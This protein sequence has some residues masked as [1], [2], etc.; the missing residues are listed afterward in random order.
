LQVSPQ[1]QSQ[2]VAAIWAQVSLTGMSIHR[3]R[4]KGGSGGEIRQPEAEAE[5][6]AEAVGVGVGV[7]GGSTVR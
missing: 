6:E 2:A 4:R 3:A 1:Q 7:G 5:A